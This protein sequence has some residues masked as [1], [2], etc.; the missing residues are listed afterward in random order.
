MIHL[1]MRSLPK[2]EL[3]IRGSTHTH[4]HFIYLSQITEAIVARS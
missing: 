1:N 2:N 3:N 4:T